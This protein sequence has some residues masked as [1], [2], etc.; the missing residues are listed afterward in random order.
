MMRIAFVIAIFLVSAF[1]SAGESNWVGEANNAFGLELYAR[2]ASKPGNLFISPSSIETALAMTYAGAR[3]NT[4]AE[5]AKVLHL[6]EGDKVHEDLGVFLKGLNAATGPD[7]K[8][9]AFELSVANRL[10]GQKGYAIVSAFLSLNKESYGAGL[11]ELNFAESEAARVTIN[12]WVEK[13]TK[14]RIK[15]LIPRG[16]LDA[17]TR[18]VLTNA[19][20]FKGK[21]EAP[22]TKT[23]TREAPFRISDAEQVPCQMM[24]AGGD[25]LYMENETLQALKLPY[26]GKELSMIILLP[27]TNDLARLERNLTTANLAAWIG[28]MTEPMV[29][30]SF[31]RFKMT[32]AFMLKSDLQALGMKDA[33]VYPHADFTGIEPKKEFY[34]GEVLHKAFVEVNEEGTEAAA[35][36]AVIGKTGGPPPKPKVFRA[37]HPFLFV[38]RHEQ[39]GAI[40]FLGRLTDPSKQEN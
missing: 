34:V 30:V 7:G 35:A 38:I 10:W 40:L 32:A 11:E 27:K 8:P 24:S 19:I 37:D 21:W 26:Q 9:R 3:G 31:P 6:P 4:A 14:D 33:F 20:Y 12:T 5:M 22:F 28:S 1:V 15:N 39:S 2:L 18:L 29:S 25:H 23:A 13:Q 16:V 17:A 36:T